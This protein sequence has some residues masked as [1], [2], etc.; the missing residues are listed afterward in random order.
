[1]LLLLAGVVS[2]R[3]TAWVAPKRT[4][5]S[6]TSAAREGAALQQSAALHAKAGSFFNQ[7]PDPPDEDDNNDSDDDAPQTSMESKLEDVLKQHRQPPR[8]TQPST[9]NG[10]PSSEAGKGFGK[11]KLTQSVIKYSERSKTYVG[12][13]PASVNDVTKPAYDDQGY[14]LYTDERTGEKSRV[15]EALVEYPCLFTMKIVGAN[16]G[17]FVTDILSIVAATCQVEVVSD[18]EHSVK[19]NGKWSSVT[20][21]A[22]VQ[23]AEMLYLLYENLDRDPRVKF[24]F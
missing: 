9:I 10:V 24:K 6:L 17:A 13:G 18:I 21:E 3:A 1:M 19:V 12:I 7:V 8:A 15:F 11:P 5:L 23:S 14:T 20:V 22:P 4:A 16:E 2:R